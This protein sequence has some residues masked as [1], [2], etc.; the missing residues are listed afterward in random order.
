[1]MARFATLTVVIALSGPSLTA[2]CSSLPSLTVPA[3]DASAQEDAAGDGTGATDS[4]FP[5]L[6][7]ASDSASGGPDGRDGGAD[8]SIADSTTADTSNSDTGASESGEPDSGRD[9]GAPDASPRFC[10]GGCPAYVLSDVAGDAGLVTIVTTEPFTVVGTIA[11]GRDPW[12]IA[13]TPDGS[14]AY[15]TEVG[16][17]TVSVID[18]ASRT[19]KTTI[20]VTTP[21]GL[22]VRG[23]VVSPDGLYAYVSD[24]AD[25]VVVQIDTSTDTKTSTTLSVAAPGPYGLAF[26]PDGGELWTGGPGGNGVTR[27]AYP[28]LS[29]LGTI[30]GISG[31]M[32]GDRIAFRPDFSAAFVNSIGGC[33]GELDAVIP[34]ADAAASNWAWLGAGYGLAMAPGGNLVYATSETTPSGCSV[35]TAAAALSI[36]DATMTTAVP[37]NSVSTYDEPRGLALSADGLTVFVAGYSTSGSKAAGITAYDATSLGQLGAPLALPGHPYDLALVP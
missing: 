13:F 22:S 35:A 5:A 26:S 7:G 6:E 36:I 23:V 12:N 3:Y 9:Q 24:E 19:V 25:S 37:L 4:G 32:T 8:S 29:S 30:S 2:A 27:F 1:M 20:P 11:V 18:T 15:V 34:G 33:F 21:G 16:D 14:K 17:G 31:N 10:D 28:A